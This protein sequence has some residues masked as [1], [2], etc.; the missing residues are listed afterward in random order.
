ME[1]KV[2]AVGYNGTL[3][4]VVSIRDVRLASAQGTPHDPGKRR[5]GTCLIPLSKPGE[6]RYLLKI[7]S[8]MALRMA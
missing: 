3:N 7:L 5:N 2:L 4:C 6:R 1:D 8:S